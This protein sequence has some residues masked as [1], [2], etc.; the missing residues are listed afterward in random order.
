MPLETLDR[1]LLGPLPETLSA[2]F[3]RHN[4]SPREIPQGIWKI[5]SKPL[6]EHSDEHM[7]FDLGLRQFL[8]ESYFDKS[9]EVEVVETY[10]QR[11][12]LGNAWIPVLV[13]NYA[14]IVPVE[15]PNKSTVDIPVRRPTP[16][17]ITT[18]WP[19]EDK[20]QL[21][22]G[23]SFNLPQEP[24][25]LDL[26]EPTNIMA[27]GNQEQS[28]Q[29]ANT[30]QNGQED[31]NV[32]VVDKDT[33]PEQ[34]QTNMY[35]RNLAR[36]MEQEIEPSLVVLKIDENLDAMTDN[37]TTFTR[38]ILENPDLG[39]SLMFITSAPNYQPLINLLRPRFTSPKEMVASGRRQLTID[40]EI[41]FNLGSADDAQTIL[42][43]SDRTITDPYLG[44][45]P[46]QFIFNDGELKTFWLAK[47]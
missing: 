47:S 20:S 28:D 4:T 19:A 25:F 33:P 23:A 24:L 2:Y 8:L 7:K 42:G 14:S 30:L 40:Q 45:T 5:V 10:G 1:A 32:W 38:F 41:F 31:A 21:P 22:L 35:Y 11:Y 29:L 13:G 44:L 3:E 17:E 9:V 43:T 26:T 18:A 39:I 6:T 16:R 46:H 37:I 15:D 36:E 27:V 12:N 34:I